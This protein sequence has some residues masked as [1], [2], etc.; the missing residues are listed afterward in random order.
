MTELVM[1]R[2]ADERVRAACEMFDLARHLMVA[3]IRAEFPHITPV[4]LRV[5]VFERTYG[6]DFTPADRSRIVSRLRG[7][8]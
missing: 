8:R 7:E 5:K 2:T 4:E 3:G 6:T 1:R